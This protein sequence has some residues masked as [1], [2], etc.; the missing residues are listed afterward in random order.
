MKIGKGYL[1]RDSYSKG[2]SHHHLWWQRVQAGR[3]MGKLSSGEKG[4]VGEAIGMG[5]CR[6]AN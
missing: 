6:Q 3:G 1:S 5:S 2:A 4:E